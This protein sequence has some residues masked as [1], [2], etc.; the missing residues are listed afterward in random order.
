MNFYITCRALIGPTMHNRFLSTVIG[1]EGYMPGLVSKHAEFLDLVKH[2]GH[3]SGT[4]QYIV[5][6]EIGIITICN[7]LERNAM[8]GKMMLQL[9]QIVDNLYEDPK[10]I[11]MKGLIITGEKDYFCSGASL[12]LAQNVV[13]TPDRGVLMAKYMTS[14]L[15]HLRQYPTI[16]VSLINGPAIGG[17]AEITTATDFR[18]MRDSA[19]IQFVH[20][21]IGAS[22]GWGGI[23]RLLS[24][25]SRN[26]ALKILTSGT[27]MSPQYAKDINLVDEI[28]DMDG[29]NIHVHGKSFLQSIYK[30]RYVGSVS[31]IKSVFSCYDQIHFDEVL[32][33]KEIE[34]FKSRWF[35]DDNIKAIESFLK[36]SKK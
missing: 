3:D 11:Q 6:D 27:K 30:G 10:S 19:Y 29:E 14:I 20:A 5:E 34:A 32:I 21:T 15:N 16:S 7:P 13:N 9:G 24:S 31:A 8:S 1:R 23:G 28:S 33:D 36:K 22:P 2:H 17:G 18:I 26:H 25:I 12:T 4:V 35:C